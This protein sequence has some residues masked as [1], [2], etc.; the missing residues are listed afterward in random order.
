M[1]IIPASVITKEN[2]S[3]REGDI[4][5]TWKM[6]NICIHT[7]KIDI[8]SVSDL[9]YKCINAINFVLFNVFFYFNKYYTSILLNE[10]FLNY[11]YPQDFYVF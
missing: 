1:I 6:I 8:Q 2:V 4:F 9:F 7:Q 10:L 11:F 3:G 5:V